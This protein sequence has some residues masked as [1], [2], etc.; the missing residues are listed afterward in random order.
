M[1]KLPRGNEKLFNGALEIF[2]GILKITDPGGRKQEEIFLAIQ[3]VI[4]AGIEF[5]ELRDEILVQL[6]RQTTAPKKDLPKK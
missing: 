5:P 2:K 3:Q 6:V 4:A 1:I